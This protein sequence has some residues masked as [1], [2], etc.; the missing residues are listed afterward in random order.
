MSVQDK[1]ERLIEAAYQV[2]VRKGYRNSSIKDIAAEAGITPGLVHYYFKSKEELLL[3]VQEDIQKKY[4]SRYTGLTEG[5]GADL[6]KMLEEIK[7]RA[8]S[9]PDW[10]QWRYELFS[11]GMKGEND[12]LAR[13]AASIL[14]HGRDSLSTPI[15]LFTGSTR[16]VSALAGILLACFDGLALQKIADENFD[17][18]RSY[19]LLTELLEQYLSRIQTEEG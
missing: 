14:Q 17:L 13:Q 7:S 3:S 19:T 10:Y 15:E 8:T 9:N 18:D 12:H 2:F 16:D 1:K 6:A 4:Q 11:L 5:Q